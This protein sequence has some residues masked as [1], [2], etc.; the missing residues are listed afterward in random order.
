MALALGGVVEA[1][2]RTAS[3]KRERSQTTS[4][5]GSMSVLP[6]NSSIPCSCSAST[7]SSGD[8]ESLSVTIR[9]NGQPG[10]GTKTPMVLL[11]VG[12]ARVHPGRVGGAGW[13]WARWGG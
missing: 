8:R 13:G 3:G 2:G 9:P 12:R 1:R 4:S 6:R 10:M 7:Y 5:S 11:G